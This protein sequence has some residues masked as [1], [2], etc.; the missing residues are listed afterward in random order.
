[1]TPEQASAV[2][3]AVEARDD[4]MNLA[5]QYAQATSIARRREGIAHPSFSPINTWPATAT[6]RYL[7]TR[8]GRGRKTT[9]LAEVTIYPVV[10][11]ARHF[12]VD[13]RNNV[14][15]PTRATSH[16]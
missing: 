5:E 10:G 2:V 7:Q 11:D 12:L 14:L 1:M 15:R 13:A 4:L 8:G 3:D 6:V 9:R 16:M